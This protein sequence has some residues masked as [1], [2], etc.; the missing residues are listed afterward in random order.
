MVHSK[1]EADWRSRWCKW[2]FRNLSDSS[3][4]SNNRINFHLLTKT[5]LNYFRVYQ[6]QQWHRIYYQ[7]LH[8]IALHLYDWTPIIILRFCWVWRRCNFGWRNS[9]PSL[10]CTTRRAIYM[11]RICGCR[12]NGL[13][14]DLVWLLREHTLSIGWTRWHVRKLVCPSFQP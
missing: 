4:V 13:A 11:P 5:L 2:V 8:R 9:Q 6:L 12:S 3:G 7:R 14:W 10:C 1:L